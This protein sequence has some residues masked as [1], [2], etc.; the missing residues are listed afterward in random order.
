MESTGTYWQSLYAVLIAEGFEAVLCI[1]KF[2]KNIKGRKNGCSGLRPDPETPFY[3]ACYR[4]VSF[5]TNRP[6]NYAL[7]KTASCQSVGHGCFDTE[8]DAEIFASAQSETRHR[9]Q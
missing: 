3:R 7:I 9:R 4:E 8:E 2:T 1:G 5:L 6:N